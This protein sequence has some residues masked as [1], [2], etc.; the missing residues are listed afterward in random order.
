MN[1]AGVG[2]ANCASDNDGFHTWD[3]P[4]AKNGMG[5][6]ACISIPR[7]SRAIFAGTVPYEA[8]AWWIND[9]LPDWSFVEFFATADHSDEVCFNLGWHE[10]SLKK[11]VTRRGGPQSLLTRMPPAS[12]RKANIQTLLD[13]CAV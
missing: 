9:H 5:A 11:M 2:K 1:A 8:L 4:S 7:V 13:N 3:H 12:E 10:I 6:T